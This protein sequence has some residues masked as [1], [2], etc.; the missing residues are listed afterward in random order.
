MK[1]VLLD[2]LA[3][4]D[5]RPIRFTDVPVPVPGR[6]QVLVKVAACGVC[7]S[8]LH[9]IEGDWAAAGVPSLLPIIPGHEVVGRIETVGEGVGDLRPGERVGVQPLWSTCGQCRF[10][11]RGLDQL[12]QAKEITGE[13]VDGGYAEYML[14]TAEH[15]YRI[16]DNLPDEQAAPLFCPG[17]TAYAAVEKATVTPGMR[18]AVF[19]MGGVGHMVVQFARVAGAEVTVVARGERHRALAEELGASQVLDPSR[20]AE[21]DALAREG[22]DASIVF[23]PSDAALADAI[24]STSP[25][26]TIVVG[27]HAAIPDFPFVQEKRV[28]GS[29]LGTRSQMRRVIELAG[30]G[31][32][33]TVCETFP[34][35]EAGRAL[36]QLKAGLI[37]A[38]AV[39]SV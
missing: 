2:R 5:Q 16:P 17:I 35:S 8:N 22:V 38:R 30:A 33:R 15:T 14:A 19:G 26:G 37:P 34:L 12:C 39:L 25:G 29:V 11:R 31:K 7:R 6:G 1:A 3:P 23:A 9:M 10:C 27:V 36:E 28:I 13:T 32:V 18:L 24:R 20:P 4:L 21:V